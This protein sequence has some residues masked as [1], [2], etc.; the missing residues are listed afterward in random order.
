MALHRLRGCILISLVLAW[1][2]LGAV[3]AAE[4]YRHPAGAFEIDVPEGWQ[5]F[6]E[7]G[8]GGET[9]YSVVDMTTPQAV[10]IVYVCESG[11]EDLSR[12]ERKA[13]LDEGDQDVVAVVTE[14]GG[15]VLKRRRSTLDGQL[16]Q[17]RE[18]TTPLEQG[19]KR[20]VTRRAYYGSCSYY[21]T[22]Y[23]LEEG[24]RRS[25]GLTP[26]RQVMRTFKFLFKP[27]LKKP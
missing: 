4:V 11:L 1:L 9:E 13:L 16:A 8:E 14:A 20:S 15:T 3:C 2:S 17:D 10:V 22:G 26:V 21:V 25:R 27:I 12:K 19:F 23:V 7:E 6:E 18:Y 5:W 24:D